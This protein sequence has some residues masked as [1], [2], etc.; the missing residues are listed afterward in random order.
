V[1][2]VLALP[3]GRDWADFV[4]Y[5]RELNESITD[6]RMIALCGYSL[7]L[8]RP[9]DVLDIAG[10]HQFLTARRRGRWEVIETSAG[11]LAR[12][13]INRLN[14]ELEERVAQRTREL[15][16][17]NGELKAQVARRRQAE[18]AL[19]HNDRQFHALFDEAVVGIALFDPGGTPYEINRALQQMFGYSAAE[20]CSL[21]FERLLE[22]LT[23]RDDLKHAVDNLLG[24]LSG[25]TDHYRAEDRYLR[26][27]GSLFWGN[28]TVSLVRDEWNQA[29]F[30]IVVVED[31]SERKRAEEALRRTQSELAHAGRVLTMGELVASIAHEVNQP[32]T[33]VL[34]NAQACLRWLARRPPDLEE[35]SAAAERIVSNSDRAHEVI[36]R[37]RT[38]V[39]KSEPRL[40]ELDLRQ[41]IRDTAAFMQAEI[42]R[43]RLVLRLDL[44]AV[45]PTIVGDRVQLQQV[46]INLLMNGIEAMSETDRGDPAG[47]ELWL[48]SEELEARDGLVARGV[49]V[50][51]RDTGVGID[52]ATTSRLFE[53]FFT[54][55]AQGMGMGLS[56]SRSIIESHGGRLWATANSGPGATFQFE[57]P[58]DPACPLARRR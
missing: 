14:E 29:L 36:Q 47:R 4:T 19:R 51:V 26:K 9:A 21:K 6:R 53:A 35:A 25:T 17:S 45:L 50:Q 13:A 40:V 33:A 7:S 15:E 34:T 10:S 24:L 16:Q 55:K 48:R 8:S 30:G 54:T 12:T 52:A 44:A 11:K 58:A 1:G 57:L 2:G 41:V 18:E 42:A 22:R 27:D 23:H 38:L 31:I 46:M 32:L 3:D 5:E 43:Q 39:S 49:R 20:L 56:I 28:T 37:I